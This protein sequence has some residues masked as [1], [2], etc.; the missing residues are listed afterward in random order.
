MKIPQDSKLNWKEYNDRVRTKAKRAL[1]T[2][3]VVEDKKWEGDLRTL[4]RLYSAICRSLWLPSIQYI[5]LR[6]TEIN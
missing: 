3:K 5:L 6:E 2:I 1:N 4:K